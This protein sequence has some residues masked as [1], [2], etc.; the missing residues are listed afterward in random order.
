MSAEPEIESFSERELVSTRVFDFPRE[1]VYMAFSD[2][3]ALAAWWGPEGFSNT[4]QEFD[5][6]PGGVWRYVMHAPDGGDSE[7]ESVFLETVAPERIVFR[8]LRP[9]H[10][11]RATILLSEQSERTHLVWRMLFESVAECRRVRPFV[12]PANEQNLDR[13]HAHLQ[14]TR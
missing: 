8:H 2:P 11:Y 9:M 14:K 3:L 6:R 5:F 7:H 12:V 1:L 4:F 13:L 10:E